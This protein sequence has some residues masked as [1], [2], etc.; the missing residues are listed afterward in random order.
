M[1]K[2]LA[3]TLAAATIT[4]GALAATATAASAESGP[5]IDDNQHANTGDGVNVVVSDLLTNTNVLNDGILTD[6]VTVGDVDA[7]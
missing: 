3:R 1:H 7:L 5:I 6:G 2:T 4:A